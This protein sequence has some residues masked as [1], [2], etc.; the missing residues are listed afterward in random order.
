[1]DCSQGVKGEVFQS[2]RCAEG[3]DLQQ[4]RQVLCSKRIRTELKTDHLSVEI[5]DRSHSPLR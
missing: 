1:M 5:I 3:W 4:G 2:I